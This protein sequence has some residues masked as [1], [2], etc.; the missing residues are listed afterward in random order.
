MTIKRATTLVRQHQIVE[1]VRKLIITDGM[2]HVTI[3]TIA[4]E[5]GLSEGAIYRYFPSKHNILLVLIEELEQGLLKMVQEARRE[6]GPGLASLE[7][8]FQNH[9]THTGLHGGVSFILVAEVLHF[10]DSRLREGVAQLLERYLA[11]IREIL[12]EAMER[13][14]LRPGIDLA[15]AATL[16]LGMVQSTATLWSVSNYAFPLEERL[17]PLWSLYRQSIASNN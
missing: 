7:K 17:M 14:E 9:L 1:A 11:V 15:R 3:E 6:A 2:E 4:Q 8:V 13:E 5:I 10:D 16:F 12:T